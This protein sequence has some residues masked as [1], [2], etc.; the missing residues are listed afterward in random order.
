MPPRSPPPPHMLIR[1]PKKEPGS[2]AEAAHADGGAVKEEKAAHADGGAVKEEEPAE[3]TRASR[4]PRGSIGQEERLAE[5]AIEDAKAA[6]IHEKYL[7]S[8]ARRCAA[9]RVPAAEMAAANALSSAES[10]TEEEEHLSA[11]AEAADNTWADQADS[12]A[13][14][15]DADYYRAACRAAPADRREHVQGQQPAKRQRK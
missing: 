6:E 11:K 14:A 4:A 12:W 7:A 3:A 9:R 13:V 10:A 8:D 1:V 2:C 15:H 5:A